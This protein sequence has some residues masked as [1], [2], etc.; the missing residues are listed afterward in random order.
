[1]LDY[2]IQVSHHPDAI[3]PEAWNQL[4]AQ[5]QLPTPFM[6]HEYLSALHHS[7]SALPQ[8]G[9]TPHFVTLQHPATKQLLAGW[10]PWRHHTRQMKRWRSW[11]ARWSSA[12][13]LR[14]LLTWMQYAED[15]AEYAQT[16]A[17]QLIVIKQFI[18]VQKA[19]AWRQRLAHAAWR[20]HR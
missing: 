3:A 14:A 10:E 19:R 20:R 2:V 6:R 4:L 1:M 8:T 12:S 17:V 15:A 5:Q 11:V 9:W 13:V 18:G 16:L 7:G